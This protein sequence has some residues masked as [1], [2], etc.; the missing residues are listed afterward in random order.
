MAKENAIQFLKTFRENEN[1]EEIMKSKG[2]LEDAKS[3]A[4]ALSEVAAE[5]GEE[6]S[7]EDFIEAMEVYEAEMRQKTD[8]VV[9]MI[10]ELEDEEID[11]VA[12]GYKREGCKGNFEGSCSGVDACSANNNIYQ[13]QEN[14]SGNECTFFNFCDG[15]FNRMVKNVFQ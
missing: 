5:M 4:K 14:Y 3:M 9:S 7:T 15:F 10:E 2:E 12:G 11:N 1:A 6:I 8:S 13:C